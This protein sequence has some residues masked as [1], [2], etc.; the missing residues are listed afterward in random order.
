MSAAG[1]EILLAAIEELGIQVR[2]DG[3]VQHS[4]FG[5]ELLGRPLAEAYLC[6][7]LQHLIHSGVQVTPV[8]VFGNCREVDTA[9]DLIRANNSMGYLNDQATHCRLIAQMGSQLLSEANDLKRPLEIAAA[10]MGVELPF[11]EAFM[12][13]DIE[14]DTAHEFLRRMATTYPVALSDLLVET[15]D[16][17]HGARIT[18]AAEGESTQRIL[19]RAD[20]HG[21]R[22]PYYEY[23]DSAM[24]RLGP[25]RPEWIK[26]LR[27]VCR[28][29][30]SVAVSLCNL[31]RIQHLLYLTRC[32]SISLGAALSH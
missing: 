29:A 25:F 30:S 12:N 7:L 22:T 6:D 20:K 2:A 31:F 19:D 5:L 21:D 26:E 3:S 24:S 14:L 28:I 15:D 18:T 17:T 16:T 4:N 9:H 13:G 10:E 8:P 1:R 23:R 32:C 11:L 27:V